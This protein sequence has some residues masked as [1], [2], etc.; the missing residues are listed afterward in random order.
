M[1]EPIKIV[2]DD[3]VETVHID[4]VTGTVTEDQP[5][6][7][8]VVHLDAQRNK[9]KD[10]DDGWY[11]NL[12]NDID[13]TKLGVI[14]NDLYSA[15]DADDQSRQQSL[16]NHARGLEML[17]IKLEKPASGVDEMVEGMSRVTNPLL[18]EACLKG[19][20]NSQ[21][22]LLPANGPVKIKNDGTETK[23]EDELAEALERGF[24]HY[25]TQ[26][27]KEYYPDT[28]QMLLWGTHF[29]GAGFKKVYRCPMRRRPVSE[30][31]DAK[32][33]IVSDAT[34]DISSCSRITHQIPMRPSVFKRM[35][36]LGVY[37]DT[38]L[39]Q[40]TP[41]PNVV[42]E[43]IATIQGVSAP[44]RPED[45][46]YTIWETQC[47]LDIP[48]FAPGK[49][50]D[51][52]I[53]LPYLVSMDKDTRE[54]LSITRDWEEDDEECEREQ[55]YVR[56]PYV[57]GPGFYCTGML[58]ILGNASAA[59]TAAW[60]EALDAG[61]FA[62]FPAGLIA[63][64]GSRQ[65]SATFRLAPGTFEPVETNGMP[66]NQI[67]TG[68]PYKDV[69]PGLLT[70]I[71][72]IT[73]QCKALGTAA[74]VPAGEGL[75]NIP[76]GTMLAQIEQATKIMAAAHKG[77]HTAQSEEFALLIKLFRR[78]PEDFWRQNKECP[79][80]YWTD[81]KLQMAFDN[82]NLIPVSDPNVPSHVH[83]VAKALGLVQLSAMP[84]FASRLDPDEVLR[85]VLAAMKEDPVGLVVQAP[86]QEMA[87]DDK[88]KMATAQAKIMEVQSKAGKIQ[89]ESQGNDVKAQLK[90]MEIKSDERSDQADI[91]KE[92]IIHQADMAKLQ[93]GERREE[94][95]LQT[96][97]ASEQQA[98]QVGRERYGLDLVKE[99]LGLESQKQQQQHEIAMKEKE[100][101]LAQSSHGLEI[102]KQGLAARD[103][104]RA[105]GLAVAQHEHDKKVDA[106]QLAIDAH[107]ATH[108]PKPAA[109]KPKPKKKGK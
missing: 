30:A 64:L 82:C 109:S 101:G 10:D 60:R 62:N 80:D 37:R 39:T 98:A 91:R 95:K 13:A 67:V 54:I 51:E 43:K 50:E 32:D 99:G 66:I 48:E 38:T 20:A 100:H 16:Q 107:K 83:R 90:L 72:K 88:A 26:T 28:S 84:Q 94:L 35:K 6:G 96:K 4:P 75:A 45:Q 29:R 22:E 87:P 23:S 34:K 5:D 53:P 14:A 8:V 36:L 11:K 108:P 97:M 77:M 69:T 21:A 40:P 59:M 71:D 105:H 56:Y 41:T 2:I 24:N 47:E 1:A 7:G 15:I 86:P 78:N 89:A 70:L 58:N 25:L 65:N 46:P 42:T 9:K 102:H 79:K 74:E 3:D 52:G 31:V 68:L 57:P 63:K 55:M 93:S 92:E 103:S 17:G 44:T 49:F 19:W 106:A 33:L 104:D 81:V 27:A 18:L 76:V 61:M 73:E 12:A 85:R